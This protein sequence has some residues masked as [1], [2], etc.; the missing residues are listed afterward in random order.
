[1]T[2]KD[3]AERVIAEVAP[4]AA[5]RLAAEPLRALVDDFGLTVR[6]V[7]SLAGR[8]GAGGWCDGMSFVDEGVVLISSAGNRRDNFTGAHELAHAL[9]DGCDPA[10][11]WV[12]DQSDPDRAL[13]TLCDR[14][15]ARLLLPLQRVTDILADDA[16]RAAHLRALH[17]AS[18]ASEPVCAIALAARLPCQGA[19]LI[20]DLD[21]PTVRYA[22]VATADDGWPVAFPWPGREIPATHLLRRIGPHEQRSE[23]SWWATP[24]GDRQDY[25]LDVVTSARCIHA[26]LSVYD[27]WQVSAFHGADRPVT[28][29]VPELDSACSC[30]FRGVIRGY[31]CSAC[32]QPFCPR[33]GCRC[34]REAAR[35]VDCPNPNCYMRVLPHLIRNGRCVNCE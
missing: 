15:A 2:I 7:P 27:L 35:L 20:A 19:V 3:A 1:M 5:E 4:A 24:W 16:P 33:C 14:V 18:A 9:V 13:E 34:Q 29:G 30:G 25:Y 6:E 23:R 31:P 10:L 26:V 11:D 28:A 8:R 21:D 17:D 32:G 22:T 12:A